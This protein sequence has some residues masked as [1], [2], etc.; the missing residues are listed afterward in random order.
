[1]RDD[2]VD[3]GYAARLLRVR[4]D[5]RRRCAA[6]GAT[7]PVLRRRMT[8]LQVVR[9]ARR[10][11]RS[12]RAPSAVV[13]PS[14]V[15][16]CDAACV[17]SYAVW[18]V[19]D[20]AP[21]TSATT[22]NAAP[23]AGGTVTISGLSF[24]AAGASVTASLTAAD[25]CGSSAWTSKT[26]V[27]CAPQAYGG[28]GGVRTAVSVSGVAGTLAEHFSFDGAWSTRSSSSRGRSEIARRRIGS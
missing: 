16:C 13:S 26:T 11:S 28:T 19:A 12:N 8:L 18:S 3:V 15:R 2:V 25:T 6:A 7:F 5:R 17:P 21:V 4:A 14:M 24:G 27:V 1:M 22:A 23:T 20:T 10:G 9:G